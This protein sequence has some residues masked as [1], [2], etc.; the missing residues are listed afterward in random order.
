VGVQKRFLWRL[1][2]KRKV[3]LL[4]SAAALTS[5]CAVGPNYKRPPANV[6]AEFKEQEGWKP[7]EPADAVSRGNWWEI[8]ND[9]QLNELEAQVNIS[10]QNIRAS[11]AAV[12]NAQALVSEANAGFWPILGVTGS[13]SRDR[14]GRLPP[15]RSSSLGGQLSWAMDIWGQ[16]R[17]G[18]EGAHASYQAS[19]AALASARLS[20]QAQLAIAYFELRAQDQTQALLDDIVD[21]EQKSLEITRSR[22][23]KG[24]VARADVVTAQTQLLGSQAQQANAAVQRGILEHAIAVLVGKTPAELTI[25]PTAMRTDVPTIPAGVPSVL[26]ERRPDIAAAE[27]KVAAAN[28]QIGV[29]VA[30]WFPSLS[31]GGNVSYSGPAIGRLISL[32]NQV[33]SIGPTLALNVLDGGLRRAQ[34]KAARA[35]WEESVD[36]YRQTVL[37][38]IQQVEDELITLRVSE[39]VQVIQ[40]QAVKAAKEAEELTLAQYKAGTVNYISVIQAQTTRFTAQETALNVFLGRLTASVTLIEAVGGGWSAAELDPHHRQAEKK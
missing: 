35:S 8:F 29:A 11:V 24:V 1:G 12:E 4:C 9:P 16:L 37:S 3:V 33:W 25:K 10:N 7:S 19:E 27:R 18:A 38:G 20:A 26:L 39:K 28:A 2:R 40:D 22:Y 30:A 36:N 23:S 14:E 6:T 31:I 34:V 13:T 5:A 32:P 15:S 21:A 17:R